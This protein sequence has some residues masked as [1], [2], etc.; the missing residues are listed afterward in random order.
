[1]SV[2]W[3]VLDYIYVSDNLLLQFIG[4]CDSFVSSEFLAHEFDFS[5][6]ESGVAFINVQ[7]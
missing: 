4:H 1:M 3:S 6:I 5:S 7:S 2:N